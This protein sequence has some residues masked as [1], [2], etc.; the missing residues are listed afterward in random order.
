M[1][2]IPIKSI[3]IETESIFVFAKEY[4]REV[5]KT[6]NAHGVLICGDGNILELDNGD[7]YILGMYFM[8]LN[9]IL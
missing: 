8:L 5:M 7:G 1:Y 2:E 3:Y 9:L 4:G 6:D